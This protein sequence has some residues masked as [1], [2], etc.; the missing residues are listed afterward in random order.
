VFDVKTDEFEK[1]NRSGRMGWRGWKLVVWIF[2]IALAGMLLFASP[3]YGLFERGVGDMRVDLSGRDIAVAECLLDKQQVAGLVQ[4][5][6]GEGMAQGVR[7]NRFRDPRPFDPYRDQQLHGAGLKSSALLID[8]QGIAFLRFQELGPF[9]AN[10]GLDHFPGTNRQE[11][12]DWIA[13]LGASHTKMLAVYVL[14][15]QS[16]QLTYP[17]TRI[18]QQVDDGGIPQGMCVRTIVPQ[19][20]QQITLFLIGQVDR[21]FLCDATRLDAGGRIGL[22]HASLLLPGE[23]R[24]KRSSQP[25]H[26]VGTARCAVGFGLLTGN[27]DIQHRSGDV[28]RIDDLRSREGTQI[29]QECR[30]GVRGFASRSEVSFEGRKGLLPGHNRLTFACYRRIQRAVEPSPR[31]GDEP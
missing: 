25:V 15:V 11:F 20:T 3:L 28:L 26:T 21:W 24:S 16:D 29:S 27:E 12:D 18:Q 8:E 5:G 6:C 13:A 30:N 23:E 17:D 1:R 7:R 14:E 4:Q 19:A 22:N 31:Q 10:V 9:S 2:L